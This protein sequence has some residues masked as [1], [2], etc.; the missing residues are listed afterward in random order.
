M[1]Q[2]RRYIAFTAILLIVGCS[3]FQSNGNGGNGNDHYITTPQDRQTVRGIQSIMATPPD[4]FNTD[5][6]EIFVD[7]SKVVK[8]TASPYKYEWDTRGATNGFHRIEADL[9]SVE[10]SKLTDAITVQVDNQ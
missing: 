9:Y 1:K 6:V 7:Q 2:K 5:Y 3:I 10:G 4:K 8:A